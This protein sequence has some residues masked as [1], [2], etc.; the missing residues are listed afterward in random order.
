MLCKREAG[1]HSI[2]ALLTFL[3]QNVEQ[4]YDGDQNYVSKGRAENRMQQLKT[5]I[6]FISICYFM[7]NF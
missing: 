6:Y 4:D 7:K 5:W 3:N 2:G 1:G